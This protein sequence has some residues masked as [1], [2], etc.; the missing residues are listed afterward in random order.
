MLGNLKGKKFKAKNLK[1]YK[2]KQSKRMF[3]LAKNFLV[4]VVTFNCFSIKIALN[5]A[6]LQ[7]LDKEEIIKLVLEY[8]SKFDSTITTI[9]NI[10]NIKTALSELRK[11]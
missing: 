9:N 1:K 5:E 3:L 8:Q 4:V 6:A 7:K 11:Y 10:K 2:A